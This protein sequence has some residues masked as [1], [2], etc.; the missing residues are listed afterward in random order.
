V[1][2]DVKLLRILRLPFALILRTVLVLNLL[3]VLVPVLPPLLL[4]L[5][6]LLILLLTLIPKQQVSLAW[7]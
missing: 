7:V 1:S 5:L 4:L 2:K 6:Q 3:R